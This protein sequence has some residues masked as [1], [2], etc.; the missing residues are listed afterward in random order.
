MNYRLPILFA[1]LLSFFTSL[2]AQTDT[3]ALSGFNIEAVA[4]GN[5]ETVWV[6]ADDANANGLVPFSINDKDT[7][8]Q[9]TNG[10]AVF[11][12]NADQPTGLYFFAQTLKDYDFKLYHFRAENGI[13]SSRHLP[14]WLS[15]LPPLMAIFLALLFKEVLSSLFAGVFL[16]AFIVNGM[17]LDLIPIS[18]FNTIDKYAITALLDKGHA[19]IILFSLLIGGMV[20][21]IS[22]NGGM[23]GIVD[24]LSTFAKTRRSSSI[25]A[26]FLGIVIFFDDY[27]NTLI[28][29]NTMK[30]LA[31][32]FKM[33]REKLAYI[34][35]STAAPVASIA[36]IT[37][38]IGAELGYIGDA[39]QSLGLDQNAY[40]MF[41]GSLEY[42]YYP[43]FTLGFIFMLIWTKRD[44]GPMH[45][46][47][48]KAATSKVGP[49]DHSS[50]SEEVKTLQVK[51]GIT[52]N[53][54]YAF[55][56]VLTV[57][58]VTVIGLLVTGNDPKVWADPNMGFLTKLSTTIGNADSYRSLL[59][60]SLSGILVAIIMT[61]GSR[62][63]GVMETADVAVKGF[64][65]LLIAMIILVSAWS[66]ATITEELHTAGFLTSLMV[67]K[68]NPY[69]MPAIT[70]ILAAG[71]SFSTGS[72]WSTMAI[73]FP[74]LL[75]TTWTL[76]IAAGIDHDHAYA[77]MF[78]VIATIMGGSV[79]G[80]HCS[81]IS[82]TTILSSLSTGC[83]HIEHVRTQ[84]PY[85]ITVGA[86]SV[87]CGG[88]LFYLRLPWYLLYPAGFVILWLIV[89][90]FGKPVPEPVED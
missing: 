66:L 18:L 67:G 27:A 21:I 34:V 26:W 32:K 3:L 87:V 35:D 86:V 75:P 68:V 52:P 80:D 88:L 54:W 78:N 59:W 46:A 64:K 83:N 40:G 61:V 63:M 84:M 82:D 71:V 58:V 12:L 37:T 56:P 51:E 45:T 24:K 22:R 6:V 73:L 60:S 77:I 57:V 15:I 8:L 65:S 7:L 53:W 50:D 20:A 11:V 62:L 47:E 89:R 42:A 31:D 4:D 90:Y 44:F 28:V 33:S 69:F 36:F 70:F 25:I 79:F 13:I 39:I 38:W 17:H 14:L 1:V 9:F 48:L 19:S 81:P 74:I 49:D 41:I 72:S 16:G 29:G 43:I 2:S 10:R 30:P 5:T 76:C 23:Q 55:L 85:A